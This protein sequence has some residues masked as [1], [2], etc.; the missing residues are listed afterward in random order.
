[1]TRIPAHEIAFDFDGVIADT[2]R[3][4]VELAKKNY[5]ASFEYEDITDYDFLKVIDIER[6]HAREIIDVL[7]H[8]PH[9]IGLK[10]N[11]GAIDVLT[12]M[13]GLSPVLLVTAR[14]IGEPIERWFELNAPGIDPER[15]RVVATGENTAKLEVLKEEGI[16]YFIEDRVD[17]CRLLAPEGITP[18][19]Y[20]QPWNREDHPFLKVRNWD[21]I[22]TLISWPDAP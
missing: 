21:E 12:R 19:V 13:A 4:F 2:F 8:R 18:I 14:P 9:E 1:M 11:S 16:R 5:Q 3:L 7:T 10:P 15:L 17:T 22:S 20:E 6:E